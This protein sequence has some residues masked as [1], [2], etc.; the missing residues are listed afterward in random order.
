MGGFDTNHANTAVLLAGAMLM[1]AGGERQRRAQLG[2][3][4]GTQTVVLQLREQ[5]LD[6]IAEF[7]KAHPISQDEVLTGC[8]ALLIGAHL[9]R[10]DVLVGLEVPAD[11]GTG[12]GQ[13]EASPSGCM[14]PL[15]LAVEPGLSVQQYL[16]KVAE[17]QFDVAGRKRLLIK[18]APIEKL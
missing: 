12:P 14:L 11:V 15:R 4:A 6:Q 18:I 9:D 13:G 8:Y 7:S 1:L 3:P 17:V 2:L 5:R 10:E 16:Q